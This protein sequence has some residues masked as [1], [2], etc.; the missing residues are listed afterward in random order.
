MNTPAQTTVDSGTGLEDARNSMQL[1]D[2]FVRICADAVF[3]RDVL[4]IASPEGYVSGGAAG[5]RT[6]EQ[7]SLDLDKW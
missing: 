7:L 2:G 3:H 6:K 5:T 4:K 1:D